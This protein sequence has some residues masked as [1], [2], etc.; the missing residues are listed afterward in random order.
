MYKTVI[1]HV[2]LHKDDPSSGKTFNRK[3]D[4]L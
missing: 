1:Q 4:Q 2:C 3:F